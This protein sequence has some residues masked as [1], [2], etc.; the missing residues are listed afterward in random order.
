LKLLLII[1]FPFL[2][3]GQSARTLLIL[4][5]EEPF[6]M[7]LEGSTQVII[8]L[9]GSGTIVTDWG[10]GTTSNLALTTSSQNLTHTYSVNTT[11]TVRIYNA[12]AIT[13][14]NTATNNNYSFSLAHFFAKMPNIVNFYCDGSN[15]VTG[16][17]SSLPAGLTIFLLGGSNTVTGNL[18]SLPAGL[19]RL[20]CT[21]SNTIAGDLN[22]L[23]V[24]LTYL[25]CT[26]SN[27]VTGNLSSLPAG[28]T[29][30][31]LGGSNT[32]TGNLSS[33]P[34]GLTYFRCFGLNSVSD[35][36]SPKTWPNNINHF[37]LTPA[38]GGLSST[39]MDNLIIDL[40]GSTWAGT[41]R[42]LTLTGTN[43]SR[44]SASDAAVVSLS[45]KGVT[46]VTN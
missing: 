44:T 6:V 38:S 2:L 39:E 24:A 9:Q 41:S 5:E 12:G 46:V 7:T 22:S 31:I 13:Y 45:L 27:T 20:T 28:L 29:T 40:N 14:F 43:A 26:G 11:Y 33:L 37:Q 23:P 8:A 19:T 15:T 21:G 42:T 35:Y 3:F 4:E 1:L 10:D 30:L 32:V 16:N 18:S 25:Y 36:T 34:A 17:L